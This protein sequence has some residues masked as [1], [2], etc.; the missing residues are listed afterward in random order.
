LNAARVKA[1]TLI[2]DGTED[3]LPYTISQQL[4]DS[5]NAAGTPADFYLFE[6]VGH[7][8][9]FDFN[10]EFVAAQAQINWFRKYLS[11]D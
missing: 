3:F 9:S 6:G 8:F 11:L 2:F 10:G 4:H 5:I 7:G 1:P